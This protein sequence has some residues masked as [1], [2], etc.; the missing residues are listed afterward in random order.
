MRIYVGVDVV[1]VRV[2]THFLSPLLK[3]E[4]LWTA[5]EINTVGISSLIFRH[6][7]I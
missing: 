6:F 3:S 1:V 2:C 7:L 4:R 5:I